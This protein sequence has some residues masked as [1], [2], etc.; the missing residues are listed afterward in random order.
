MHDVCGWYRLAQLHI[1][2][3]KIA[4][5]IV[6]QVLRPDPLICLLENSNAITVQQLGIDATVNRN[7]DLS[8]YTIDY[9]S[10]SYITTTELPAR[11]STASQY[12]RFADL[13]SQLDIARA[14]GMPPIGRMTM[15][16]QIADDGRIPKQ[17]TLTI[18]QLGGDKTFNQTNELIERISQADRNLI[19][20][21]GGM[22]ALYREVSL[23]EFP[24]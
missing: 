7:D 15:N 14:V 20:E 6:S 2:D 18:Q 1:V 19:D 24:E 13:A 17:I 11:K 22:L 9:G 21:I 12:G 16:R 5:V 10:L 23:R 4:D 3:R 8:Q